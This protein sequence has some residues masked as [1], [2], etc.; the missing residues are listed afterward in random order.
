MRYSTFAR[1]AFAS[2]PFD[3]TI[4]MQIT[5]A[6]QVYIER[7]LLDKRFSQSEWAPLKGAGIRCRH[8]RFPRGFTYS[9]Y[10]PHV[11]LPFNLDKTRKLET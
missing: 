1:G 4:A 7:R 2:T 9:L 11:A 10:R 8:I 3:A 6:I 5:A